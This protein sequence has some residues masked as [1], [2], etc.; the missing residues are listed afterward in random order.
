VG[1]REGSAQPTESAHHERAGAGTPQER[2]P[3]LPG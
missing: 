2:A 1:E 3:G